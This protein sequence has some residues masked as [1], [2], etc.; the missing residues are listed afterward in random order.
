M[1]DLQDDGLRAWF[2]MTREDL[3]ETITRGDVFAFMYNNKDF[4]VEDGNNGFIIQ[5]PRVGLN[6]SNPKAYPYLDH[7]GHEQ[8]KTPAE[9]RALPFLDGKTIFERFDELR[10]YD[11]F[12]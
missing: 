11:G 9:L 10:F 4:L 2:D 7:P 12:E 8:A 3:E 5:D 1:A 6:K